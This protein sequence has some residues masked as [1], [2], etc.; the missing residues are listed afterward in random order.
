MLENR[1]GRLLDMISSTR[2]SL[3]ALAAAVEEDEAH[4]DE[5]ATKEVE[6]RRT[7]LASNAEDILMSL[8]QGGRRRSESST[9]S[10]PSPLASSQATP[11]TGAGQGLKSTVK[12]KANKLRKWLDKI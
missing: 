2:E 6:S 7:R 12:T 8:G 3:L 5:I 1:I 4:E 9:P 11:T 10:N